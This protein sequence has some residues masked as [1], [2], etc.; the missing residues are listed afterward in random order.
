[1]TLAEA[2]FGDTDKAS[3]AHNY[4]P[5]YEMHLDPDK[6]GTLTEIGVYTGGS[7]RMWSRWMPETKVIGIDIEPANYVEPSDEPFPNVTFIEGDATTVEPWASDVVIDDGSHHGD[8]QLAAFERFWPLLTPGGW[9]IIEDLETVWHDEFRAGAEM[10]SFVGHRTGDAL[11]HHSMDTGISE[12]HAY[13][14][15]LFMR[16]R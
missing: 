12:V 13:E 11:R 2:C 8:D 4:L 3:H 16:K 6:I 9:Y 14:Q 7:L 15:I 10:E 1:M 5:F